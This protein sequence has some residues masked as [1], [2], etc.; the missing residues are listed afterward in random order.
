LFKQNLEYVRDV[1]KFYEV[2]RICV[3][4]NN[5]NS[6]FAKGNFNGKVLAV[7]LEASDMQ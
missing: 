5:G 1:L 3:L 2:D 6:I 7:H 4:G